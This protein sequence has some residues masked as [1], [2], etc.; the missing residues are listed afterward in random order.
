MQIRKKKKKHEGRK[1]Y[2][3]SLKKKKTKKTCSH[4]LLDLQETVQSSFRTLEICL[5]K[6]EIK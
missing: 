2:N 1:K 4:L 3:E 5:S 6:A